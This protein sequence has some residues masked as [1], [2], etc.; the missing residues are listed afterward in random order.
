MIFSLLQQTL[1]EF[2]FRPL[3]QKYFLFLQKLGTPKQYLIFKNEFCFS[4]VVNRWTRLSEPGQYEHNFS[5]NFAERTHNNRKLQFNRKYMI[6][7]AHFLL[8]WK[9]DVRIQKK[10]SK[11]VFLNLRVANVRDRKKNFKL[12]KHNLLQENTFL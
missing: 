11:I 7:H 9:L 12:C 4:P 2:F 5:T 3:G 1:Y 6:S 8:L 10:N